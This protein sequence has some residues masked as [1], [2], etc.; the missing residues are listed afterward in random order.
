VRA[1]RREAQPFVEWVAETSRGVVAYVGFSP[2]AVDGLAAGTLAL[3]LAPL[4]VEPALQRSGL[5]S[6]LARAGLAEC[7][8]RGAGLVVVLG[9]RSY[10]P[11]FGFRPARELGLRYQSEAFD[12]SFFAKELVPGAARGAAGLVRFHPAFDRLP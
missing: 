4:A 7:A 5:G 6:A 9:H 2:V 8:A 1:L 10:Y 3:G 12:G 11:R